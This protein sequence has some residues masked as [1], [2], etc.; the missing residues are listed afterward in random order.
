MSEAMVEF[1]FKAIFDRVVGYYPSSVSMLK[2]HSYPDRPDLYEVVDLL[3][4][5]EEI[6]SRLGNAKEAVL[7]IAMCDAIGQTIRMAALFSTEIKP[8]LLRYSKVR[9][10]FHKRLKRAENNADLGWSKK[11]VDIIRMYFAVNNI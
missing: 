2:L 3:D 10:N 9:D 7:L 4:L 8:A 6:V 5:T 11:D 1:E